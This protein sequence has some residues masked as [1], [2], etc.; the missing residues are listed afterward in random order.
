MRRGTHRLMPER[1]RAMPAWRRSAIGAGRASIRCAPMR[2]AG[3]T[4]VT[5]AGAERDAY[6]KAGGCQA[7]LA[8]AWLRFGRMTSGTLDS[9]LGGKLRH[10]LFCQERNRQMTPSQALP[11]VLDRIDA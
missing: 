6:G 3:T 11:A 5:L 1:D 8:S 7:Q 2:P 10:L 4:G 9:M